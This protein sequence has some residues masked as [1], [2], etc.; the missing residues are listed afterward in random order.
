MDLFKRNYYVILALIVGSFFFISGLSA[1]YFFIKYQKIAS[2]SSKAYLSPAYVSLLEKMG[3]K[4]PLPPEEPTIVT[5]N[6]ITKAPPQPFL[7][8]AKNGDVVLI[9]KKAQKAILYDPK[10]NKVVRVGSLTISTP[11][12]E[13]V[14]ASN[15]A[16]SK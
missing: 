16:E 4:M 3:N 13:T 8:G 11:T 15:S 6:D 5:I 2:I 10:A 1:Y 12:P 7:E 9:Y 14:S